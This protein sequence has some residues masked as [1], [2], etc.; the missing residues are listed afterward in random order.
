MASLS[1]RRSQGPDVWP[2]FVDALATLVMVVVFVLMVF[3]IFQFYLK[4]VISGRDEEL[5][6]LRAD[7]AQLTDVLV[8]QRGAMTDLNQRLATTATQL[9]DAQATRERL[10]SELA[11]AGDVRNRLTA[12]LTETTARAQAAEE[13]VARTAE[14]LETARQALGAAQTT[15][16]ADRERIEMQL[17]QLA[18][19]RRGIENLTTLRTQLEARIAA[20]DGELAQ[21]RNELA[22]TRGD[23]GR[24]EQALAAEREE[25]ARGRRLTA[26]LQSNVTQVRAELA[27]QIAELQ[28]VRAALAAEA[29]EAERR[30]AAEQ[31]LSRQ[32]DQIRMALMRS[33]GEVTETRRALAAEERARADAQRAAGSEQAARAA[34]EQ[35]L[36]DQ[37]TV[38]E[39]A[40]AETRSASER[41]LA[42]ARDASARALA[43]ARAASERTLAEAQA[44][45]E[46]DAR[47]L[48]EAR[49]AGERTLAEQRAA[50]E[51]ALAETQAARE[52][53]ERRAST[54]DEQVAALRG[55]LARLTGLLGT[56]QQ[57]LAEQGQQITDLN[58]QLSA[59]LAN[60]VE[61][62]TRYRSEFFGRLRAVFEGRPGIRIEGDRF[63]FESEILFAV[64][65]A[66]I[67]IGGLDQLDR[68]ADTLRELIAQIPPE[69]NWVLQIEGH[70][71][72]RP[73]A[74]RAFRSN[75]ELSVARAISVMRF[76]VDRGIPTDRIAVA[77]FG[78][79]QPIDRSETEVG[80]ARNRR[81]ELRFTAR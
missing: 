14:E 37:R 65:S 7:L 57:R 45:R 30:R 8:G 52:A 75:W 43:E 33:T 80:F 62:L 42:E 39:R 54:L 3:T 12:E 41:A 69:L 9:R 38:S 40:L 11:A 47:A 53:G 71:D 59:A 55:E 49:A 44:A 56:D 22:Q 36:A 50:S 1:R 15:I 60:R 76:L 78:E 73:V 6:R 79:F 35:A 68:V 19:L 10:Q 48:A 58:R 64:G 66:E 13:N 5:G 2:G 34:A 72:R 24:S 4:D 23:L 18:D 61:E 81:I 51:R 16:S 31:E 20:L 74:G 67:G 77:G 17:G 21:R 46:A 26:E 28:R 70:T 29:A 27:A 25:A 63:I 32:I